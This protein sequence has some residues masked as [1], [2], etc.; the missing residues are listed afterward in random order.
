MHPFKRWAQ[1][2]YSSKERMIVVIGGGV[3]FWIV[4]PLL[5]IAGSFFVD[6][7]FRFPRFVHGRVNPLIGIVFMGGGWLLANWTVK[8]QF[9]YGRGTPVPLMATQK[10]VIRGPYAYCRNP[11]TLGT[12]AFYLGVALWLGSLSAL[13][14][15]LVYPSG[16]LLY[17]KCIEERELEERF[18]ADYLEYKR[19]TPF[20]IPHLKK[21]E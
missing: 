9:S 11:M 2:E 8:V 19:K 7:G 13:G 12:T 15:A 6:H 5:I 17:I 20:L 16:I 4:I 3:V 18:G 1:R 21:R 10:L 14:L